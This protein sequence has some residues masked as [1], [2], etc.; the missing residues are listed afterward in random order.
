MCA[1][2]N[3]QPVKCMALFEAIERSSRALQYSYV[4]C[5]TSTLLDVRSAI[6]SRGEGSCCRGVDRFDV[7]LRL[8]VQHSQRTII[9]DSTFIASLPIPHMT[10]QDA[11]S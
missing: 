1:M 6:D 11:N 2:C 10:D 9:T 4:S 3:S 8:L 5:S 7:G